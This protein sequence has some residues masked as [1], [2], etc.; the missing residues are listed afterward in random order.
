MGDKH[1]ISQLNPFLKRSA[2][3]TDIRMIPKNKML[4]TNTSTN[5]PRPNS[6]SPKITQNKNNQSTSSNGSPPTQ[7]PENH[8]QKSFAE[9]IANFSFPKK[10]Q[11]IIFNTIDGIPQIEYIKALS[12]LTS[13]SNIKFTS[14]VSNNRFCVYFSSKNIADINTIFPITFLK[15][16]FATDDL[17]HIISFRRQ[18]IIK[19]KDINKLPGS[20]IIHF[21]DTNFRIFLT[22]DTLTC[23]L[24]RHTGHTS[25]HCNNLPHT[26]LVNTNEQNDNLEPQPN[27][28]KDL[29]IMS[30]DT[31]NEITP[32]SC[33]QSKESITI[34]PEQ[35]EEISDSTHT[36]LIKYLYKSVKLDQMRKK[37]C[38]RNK[39]ENT[40]ILQ[41]RIRASILRATREC[42]RRP[43]K[44]RIFRASPPL[45]QH[46]RQSASE[47][48]NGIGRC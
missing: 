7:P 21:D 14:R 15:A 45:Y 28:S 9:T 36:K 5:L 8:T 38:P 35:N 16:G 23:Y 44:T 19:N 29:L 10:D 34:E 13:P 6:N 46:N 20:L 47:L 4:N 30:N 17:S 41:R 42:I 3:T 40:K 2:I 27:T 18:T 12:I 33:A 32:P 31:P 43:T 26:K 48:A 37:N 24:C 25:A 11:A 39:G 1:A 22:D